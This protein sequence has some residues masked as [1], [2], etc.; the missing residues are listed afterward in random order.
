LVEKIDVNWP[1]IRLVPVDEVKLERYK[2][3]MDEV[4]RKWWIEKDGEYKWKCPDQ[5]FGQEYYERGLQRET[6][7]ITVVD[8]QD[9]EAI[10]KLLGSMWRNGELAGYHRGRYQLG[11]ELVK[12]HT[13]DDHLA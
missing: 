12:Q 7:V 8:I 4:S 9:T 5:P 13:K 3:C 6:R 2:I 11:K 1:K 10:E